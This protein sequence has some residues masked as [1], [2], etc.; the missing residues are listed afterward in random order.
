[1]ALTEP[2]QNPV[3]VGSPKMDGAE[4][5]APVSR[6]TWAV[7]SERWDLDPGAFVRIHGHCLHQDT[8][9]HSAPKVRV[10]FEFFK[11]LTFYETEKKN[12]VSNGFDSI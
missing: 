2:S 7:S 3:V 4:G 8:N 6:P 9:R 12:A 11:T 10:S 5:L 1:M